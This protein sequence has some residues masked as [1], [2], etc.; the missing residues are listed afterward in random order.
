M[1]ENAHFHEL[2]GNRAAAF[3]DAAC[4]D[5][6]TKRPEDTLGVETRMAVEVPVL[7]ADHGVHK[8]IGKIS[9]RGVGQL[10]R[11]DPS[12]R[13][14]VRRF[15][16]EGAFAVAGE[17]LFRRKIVKRP[18]HGAYRCGRA[19]HDSNAIVL[20]S[21]PIT[22]RNGNRFWLMIGDAW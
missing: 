13:L 8:I 1:A 4:V 21:P 7:D 12:E 10:E 16:Q 22:R 6:P 11:A 17:G 19:K 20:A 14:A 9:S 2:L 5:I 15:K 3:D 18:E